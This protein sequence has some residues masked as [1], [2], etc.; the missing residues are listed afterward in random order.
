[1]ASSTGKLKPITEPSQGVLTDGGCLKI[2]YDA[3]ST[4]GI[5]TIGG[6]FITLIPAN[7]MVKK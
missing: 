6:L 1:M 7:Y 2:D 3:F 5:D 4:Y